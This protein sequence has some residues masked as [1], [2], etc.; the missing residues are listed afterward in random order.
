M[1]AGT[2]SPATGCQPSYLISGGVGG[3]LPPPKLDGGRY[4]VSGDLDEV[5]PKLWPPWDGTGGGE[6][7]CGGGP[8][9]M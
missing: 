8:Y 7:C 4:N 5:N 1:E 6:Y 9:S 3:A 2:E